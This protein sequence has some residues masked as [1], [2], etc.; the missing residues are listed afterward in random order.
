MFTQKFNKFA[1][2][3]DT[4]ECEIDGFKA[5]ATIYPDDNTDRPDERCDG[6]WPSK[7]PKSA[8]YVDPSKFDEEMAKA[9]KVMKAWENDAWHFVGIGVRVFKA[10]VALT[11]EYT[12]ALWG[13]ECNY[14]DSDNSYLTEVANELLPEALKDAKAKLIE[15][16]S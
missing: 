3:G 2:V 13:I 14:P 5:V 7:D 11:D 4:I 16:C 15:L 8:G 6:F 9:K 10:G 12:H 1:C